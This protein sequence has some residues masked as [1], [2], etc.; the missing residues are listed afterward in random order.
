MISSM[1]GE[2]GI[3]PL[4]TNTEATIPPDTQQ[5]TMTVTQGSVVES[6]T[7]GG[8]QSEQ[9]V[10]VT[11]G[12]IPQTLTVESSYPPMTGECTVLLI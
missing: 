1:S 11:V 2:S 5:K 7:I 8:V 9:T 4:P 6:L 3:S 10:V 12:S